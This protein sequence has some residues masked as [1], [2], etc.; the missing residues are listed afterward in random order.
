M[1]SV[2]DYGNFVQVE[3][4]KTFLDSIEYRTRFALL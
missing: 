3:M 2:N 1:K 4:V